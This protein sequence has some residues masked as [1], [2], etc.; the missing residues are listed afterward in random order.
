MTDRIDEILKKLGAYNEAYRRGSPIVSDAEYDGLVETLRSIDPGHPF[1]HAVEP[2][3]FTGKKEIRHPNPMLSTDKAYTKEALERFIARVSKTAKDLGIE[4]IVYRVTPKLDG[5]AGR[6]EGGVLASR[7]NGQV[8]Y[9]ISNV[10]LK[11]VI[12]D[13]GR[14]LGV[15]EIVI[16][17]TYFDQHMAGEFEHPRN[18]VVGIVSSDTVNE[19]AQ[20]ALDDRAVR[21]VPY[22]MLAAWEGDAETMLHDMDAIVADLA[23][24]TDY[25]MDGAVAEVVN[26][27]IRKAMGSTAHHY[28]W[29]IAIKT[30]G[31]TAITVVE[32][33]TWQVGRTGNVTPVMEVRP[34][35]L[36]GATIK[37]VTAHH[38]GMVLK[39][40]IGPGA[41]IEIIRSGEV[42]PKLEKVLQG[43]DT[44]A[45]PQD[46]P[47]CGTNLTW[48]NDFLRCTNRSCKAQVEQ[49]I[50]HWFKTL[51]NADWFGIKSIQKMVAS[52]LDTLEKIYAL[53]EADFVSMG[54]GPV[55]SQNL[56]QALQ[57]SRTKAVEDWRFLAAFGIPNL[58]TGDSRKLLS[59]MPLEEVLEADRSN[60]E[61][62]NG[63]GGITSQ[64]IQEGIQQ[65]RDTMDHMLALDFNLV[66]TPLVHET[67]TAQSPISGKGIVFTGKMQH[68]SREAMQT[69]ARQL[70][71]RV[72]TAVSGTT[73]MLVCGEKVGAAK[74]SKAQSLEIEI[75]S[76][77]E[78]H[79]RIAS[80]KL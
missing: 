36:S 16:R 50:S 61:A 44:V 37:R 62:I 56:A 5:L 28:R 77:V 47:V 79:E 51:G 4:P 21:F 74:I 26:P 20:K 40:G 6:D 57:I 15:G 54:F 12:P 18:M 35:P 43:S 72:Q 48:Q 73:D 76:E 75:L 46:C 69:E 58:G 11:G 32:D 65:I 9:D 24:Q 8:G 80:S 7:G 42:I 66:K 49:G 27:E 14:G 22:S 29:Q 17:K 39:E 23:G 41:K 53:K 25:P 3:T 2:E 19:F 34:V 13:G 59:H 55:Q 78:Y 38:A 67:Q 31:E 63:F 30:K 52:G 60:I 10:F 45:L 64:S 68:G 1:L 70:G 71:A 33:V